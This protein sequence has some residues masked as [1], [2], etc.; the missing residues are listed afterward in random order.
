MFGFSGSATRS[1]DVDKDLE[2]ARAL[3]SSLLV[4]LIVP[5]T[6][7]L[8]FYS[9]KSP[10]QH[11]FFVVY[12]ILMLLTTVLHP[13]CPRTIDRLCGGVQGCTLLTHKTRR[14]L[15]VTRTVKMRESAWTMASVSMAG[16]L[17]TL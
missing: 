13:Q 7:C 10:L 15:R 12:T 8:I 16:R 3:G 1:G 17:R 5:W 14:R 2:R 9:G 6:L 11:S 4:F